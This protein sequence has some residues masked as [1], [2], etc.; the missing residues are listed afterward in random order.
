MSHVCNVVLLF[1]CGERNAH[2]RLPS[3][4]YI[5]LWLAERDMG[6]LHEVSDHG[7]NNK[8]MECYVAIGAFNYLETD[9]FVEMVMDAPWRF[10]DNVQLLVKDE[11]ADEFTEHRPVDPDSYR[12]VVVWALGLLREASQIG[13]G[14]SLTEKIKE[15]PIERQ[16][17]IKRRAKELMEQRR[18]ITV[19]DI[20]GT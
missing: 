9:E 5:N 18:S 3:L 20:D 4:E 13:L 14:V 1:G 6:Q 11:Q 16:Q 12:D 7:T 8:S 15:L 19:D 17:A 2:D 10:P